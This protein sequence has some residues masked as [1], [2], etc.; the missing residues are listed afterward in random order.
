MSRTRDAYVG[1]F[2]YQTLNHRAVAEI[3]KNIVERGQRNGLSR[4]F[5]AKNDK[6]T[7]ATWRLDLNRI[8]HVF[9]VCG[10]TSARPPLTAQF[11]TE[12]AI[13]TNVTVSDVQRDVLNTQTIVS[14]VRHDVTNAH[15]V[16]SNTHVIVSELQRNV[17]TTQT[18]VS[19]IR[20]TILEGQEG[21][22]SKNRSV[23]AALPCPPPNQHS[24]SP[25]L[26]LGW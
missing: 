9:N 17:T 14:D 12:L 5:H 23:S 25:R 6:E 24:P 26:K 2:T 1:K 19:D 22:D 18:I 10:V 8:L 20:R 4:M 7:I 21:T 13:N 11:Q 16:V 3:Q 15:A